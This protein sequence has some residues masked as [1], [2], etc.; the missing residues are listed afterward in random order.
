[1]SCL[2]GN[3]IKHISN[4]KMYV[5]LMS[6]YSHTL[7]FTKFL[8]CSIDV[9]IGTISGTAHIKAIF[10]FSPDIGKHFRGKAL[11]SS[12]SSFMHLIHVL[13]FSR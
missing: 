8:I 12:D 7:D 9:G 2:S 4:H 10:S 5:L 11:C 13:H 1:M 6:L 3:E